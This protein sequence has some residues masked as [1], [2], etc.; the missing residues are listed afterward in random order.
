MLGLLYRACDR[1][2]S[3][4]R[5]R[6]GVQT[7]AAGSEGEDRAHRYLQQQGYRVVARNWRPS[8]DA[9]QEMDLVACKDGVYVFVEV[10]TR[11]SDVEGAPDRAIDADKLLALRRLARCY[12][13]KANRAQQ[14]R[15]LDLINV[16]LH[17]RP[18]VQ[19]IPDAFSV[20]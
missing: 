20:D 11:T 15:R 8:G 9:G 17:P 16:V 18:R 19:H 13:R 5:R 7:A 2:R 3:R 6:H 12:M 1:L 14:P 10:K 4:W